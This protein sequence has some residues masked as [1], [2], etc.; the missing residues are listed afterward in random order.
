M[1]AT[2]RI[3]VGDFVIY[4]GSKTRY[5]GWAMQVTNISRDGSLSLYEEPWG[6]RLCHVRPTSVRPDPL[7]VE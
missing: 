7:G 1:S 2:K 4:Q 5:R 3:A 6:T